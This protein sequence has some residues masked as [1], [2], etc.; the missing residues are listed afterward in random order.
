M[1]L[2]TVAAVATVVS[3]LGIIITLLVVVLELKKNLRQFSVVR[4]NALHDLMVN[5]S[6][7]WSQ[8]Q[9]AEI[10][11]KGRGNYEVLT[12]VEKFIFQNFVDV[13]I[14]LFIFGYNLVPSEKSKSLSA[15]SA[16]IRHFF[17]F[18][19]V[20]ACYEEMCADNTLP[21]LWTNVINACLQDDSSENIYKIVNKGY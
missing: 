7:F 18:P 20:L 15:Q 10:V 21:E 17:N 14:R 5:F 19:G 1:N 8:H 11:M 9:N 12:D 13:R 3:S 16:R 4:E 2:E 6:S